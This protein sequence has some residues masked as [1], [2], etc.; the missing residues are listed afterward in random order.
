MT[1][2]PMPRWQ[3]LLADLKRRKVFRVAAVYGATAFGA[4]QVA[5]LVFPRL[6]LPDWTVTLV[7]ALVI[8]GFPLTVILAWVFQVTPEGIR[9]DTSP[10][11]PP[12]ARGEA[13][14]ASIAVLP[15]VDMSEDGENEYFSD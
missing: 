5:D 10:A 14:A 6:S 15:F 1:S 12:R 3:A 4:L 2:S 11:V 9:R 13:A 7:L 8:L